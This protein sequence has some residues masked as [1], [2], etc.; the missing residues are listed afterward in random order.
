MRKPSQEFYGVAGMAGNR[1]QS[2]TEPI[3]TTEN[4]E[5]VASL[6]FHQFKFRNPQFDVLANVNTFTSLTVPGR[7]RVDAE[8]KVLWEIFNDF[9]WNITFYNNFDR[10]PPGS[11]S[12][13]NDWNISTGITYT[14]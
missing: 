9:K 11:D 12:P 2:E 7:I 10:K 13:S 14:L 3:S 4:L 6:N 5:I 8:V 1:E